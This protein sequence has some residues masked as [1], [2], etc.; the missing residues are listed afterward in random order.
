[1][2]YEFQL[3]MAFVALGMITKKW[4]WQWWYVLCLFVVAWIFFN[5]KKG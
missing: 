1:M 5:W 3:L 2:K 4:K